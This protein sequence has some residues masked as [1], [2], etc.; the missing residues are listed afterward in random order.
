MS[1]ERARDADIP[2]QWENRILSIHT[3]IVRSPCG[4]SDS[5]QQAEDGSKDEKGQEDK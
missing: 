3:G 2:G 4:D 1:P 5:S